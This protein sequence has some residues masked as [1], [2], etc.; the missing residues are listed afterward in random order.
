MLDLIVNVLHEKDALSK[1]IDNAHC[2]ERRRGNLI[3]IKMQNMK[4]APGC[5]VREQNGMNVQSE[6]YMMVLNVMG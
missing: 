4:F 3:V 1:Q 5:D 6:C 2:K